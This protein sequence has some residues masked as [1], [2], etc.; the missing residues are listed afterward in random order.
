MFEPS[1]KAW[2]GDIPG[3]P[4]LIKVG[5][6]LLDHGVQMG[7]DPLRAPHLLIAQLLGG[8]GGGPRRPQELQ[9]IDQVRQLLGLAFTPKPHELNLC[10]AYLSR[11]AKWVALIHQQQSESLVPLHHVA[12]SGTTAFGFV[13][14][15]DRF[16]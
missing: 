4:V 5:I 3:G 13:R 7:R 15:W 2:I 1:T 10:P 14:Q 9:P 8:I 16:R 12:V 11:N 6:R